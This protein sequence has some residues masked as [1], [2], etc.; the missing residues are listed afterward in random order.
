VQAVDSLLK[1]EVA[2]VE[3]VGR[4]LLGAGDRR[5]LLHGESVVTGT[6]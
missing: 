1:P 6:G 3:E 4:G 2:R 5:E